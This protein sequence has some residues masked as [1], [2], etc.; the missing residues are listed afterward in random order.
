MLTC[1]CG[2]GVQPRERDA[3]RGSGCAAMRRCGDAGLRGR[4]R[5]GHRS[6]AP[7]HSGEGTC[8]P[9]GPTSVARDAPRHV[10]PPTHPGHARRP[11]P[12]HARRSRAGPADGSRSARPGGLR[13]G[14]GGGH[15]GAHLGRRGGLVLLGRSPPARQGGRAPAAGSR[16]PVRGPRRSP[17]ARRDGPDLGRGARRAAGLPRAA[18]T[19]RAAPAG[20]GRR[21]RPDAVGPAGGPGDPAGPTRGHARDPARPAVGHVVGGRPQRAAARRRDGVDG[22]VDNPARPLGSPTPCRGCRGGHG[23]GAAVRGEGAHHPGGGRGGAAGVVVD[24]RRNTQ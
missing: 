21:A 9:A 7:C 3:R 17:H 15:G 6:R 8:A 19:D 5:S 2:P 24:G 12:G 11:H 22:G 10:Q 13:A 14:G 23:S 20:R 4:R 1:G 16:V 18:G